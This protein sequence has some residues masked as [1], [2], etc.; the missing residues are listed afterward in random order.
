MKNSEIAKIVERVWE[1][2]EAHADELFNSILNMIYY[3]TLKKIND[4][5]EAEDLTQEIA[6]YIYTHIEDVRSA[7]AF[8][9]WMNC[10]IFGFVQKKKKQLARVDFVDFNLEV[11]DTAEEVKNNPEELTLSKEKQEY[12]MEVIDGLSEKQKDVILLYY[13]QQ[14]PLEHIAQILD[15]S[16]N[17]VK[18]RL[19]KARDAIK[20]Q[21]RDQKRAKE[22]NLHSI[23]LPALLLFA[24][25]KEADAVYDSGLADRLQL[26]AQQPEAAEAGQKKFTHSKKIWAMM[27][28]VC[29]GIT[30]M[31]LWAAGQ[32]SNRKDPAVTGMVAEKGFI[33]DES[34]I[35]NNTS[36]D[37][38]EDSDTP[39]DL[40]NPE[41]ETDQGDTASSPDNSD[42]TVQSKTAA[43][44]ANG[45]VSGSFS[46]HT[47]YQTENISGSTSAMYAGKPEILVTNGVLYYAVGETVTKEKI[48]QDG[49]VTAKDGIGN[50][51]TVE[52]GMVERIDASEE[53]SFGVILNT[54]DSSGKQAEQKVILIIFH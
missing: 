16:V 13:Y 52:V 40:E 42:E 29:I 34:K 17:A 12:V 48:L 23:S 54:S 44:V 15:I 2:K 38:E 35:D 11:M 50:R 41:A 18:N 24:F 5:Q 28:I 53:G 25:Q 33:A 51:L 1:N 45:A 7:E 30:G 4:R 47:E 32:G 20:R 43:A 9:T 49:G 21:L 37:Q 14:L 8:Y 19:F 3:I 39:A 46:G 22:F 36:E 31:A 6:I 26:E 27:L 10:V